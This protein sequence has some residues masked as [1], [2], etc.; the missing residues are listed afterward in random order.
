MSLPIN[1]YSLK[2]SEREYTD[3]TM[4]TFYVQSNGAPVKKFRP[5][6]VTKT[7]S[8]GNEYQVRHRQNIETGETS[9]YTFELNDAC[10]RASITRT[11]ILLKELLEM[12]KYDFDW[13]CTF[14]FD[15]ERVDRNDYRAVLDCYMK[16]V[17]ELSRRFPNAG[18]ITVPEPHKVQGY[19]FHMLLGGVSPHE[20][21]LVDSGAVH[22]SWSKSYNKLSKTYTKG[23][24]IKRENYEKLKHLHTNEHKPADGNSIYNITSFQ[25]GHTE[26]ER[27]GSVE[28]CKFYVAKYIRKNLGSGME[29]FSKR[30]FYSQNLA[31][32]KVIKELLNANVPQEPVIEADGTV[33]YKPID[34]DNIAECWTHEYH[35]ISKQQKKSGKFN[36]LQMWIENT[37]KLKLKQG[38][39]NYD[40]C[41]PIE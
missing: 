26:C 16:Y 23:K 7:D 3:K 18:Y 10:K 17:H 8:D 12:N 14:T 15:R 28:A 5:V 13:F 32:P 27:I 29:L 20:L 41:R 2:M 19:H 22:C 21:R 4:V 34:V 24:P 30:F 39:I 25:Y 11:D 6:T 37:D 36:C 33:W 40:D 1:T 35:L 31:V 9:P 38:E